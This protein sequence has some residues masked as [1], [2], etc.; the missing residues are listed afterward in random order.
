[1]TIIELVHSIYAI[2]Y[3]VGTYGSH[4]GKENMISPLELDGKYFNSSTTI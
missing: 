1:V 2:P 4:G 3:I